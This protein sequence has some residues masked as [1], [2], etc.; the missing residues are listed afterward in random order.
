MDLYKVFESI[1]IQL[2]AE[3]NKSSQVKHSGGM[4]DL[5]EDAFRDFRREYL[6]RGYGVGRG[7]FITSENF[8]S[9]ELAILFYDNDLCP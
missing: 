4:G 1:S 2:I 7:A 6:S 5:R 8:T 9:G 3:F